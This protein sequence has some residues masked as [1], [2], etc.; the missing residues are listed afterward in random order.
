MNYLFIAYTV[1]W[2]LIASYVVV[3]GKRQQQLK[4]EIKQ[5]EEWN[6]EH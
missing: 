5:L 2:V 1:I 6:Q 3:L 4:K